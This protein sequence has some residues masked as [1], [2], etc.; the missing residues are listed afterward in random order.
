MLSASD[1]LDTASKR[2]E[3]L[4]SAYLVTLLDSLREAHGRYEMLEECQISSKAIAAPSLLL[5]ELEVAR[6]LPRYAR[7]T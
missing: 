2:A 7:G 6:P 3:S 4:V 5:Q 1:D